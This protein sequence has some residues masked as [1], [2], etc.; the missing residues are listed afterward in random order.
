M[1]ARDYKSASDLVTV[2]DTTQ[3]TSPANGCNPAPGAPSHPLSAQAHPP[4]AVIALAGNTIGRAE[5]NGGNGTGFCETG[6][7]Y[8]LTKTDVHGVAVAYP[9][10]TQNC[11]PGHNS[12]GLGFGQEGDPSFT[13]T[14]GHSHAV[15]YRTNAA[16][17][18]M[19][20]VDV[21]ATLNT[22]TDPTGQFL[23]QPVAFAQNTRDEV[24]EMDVV[25]V[26]AAQPGMKQT[27]YVRQSMQVRRLTPRECERLQG[28]PVDFTLIPGDTPISKIRR[29][30]LDMD[31]V[32][33]LHR[34]GRLTFEQCMNAAADG[35]RYKALGNS[36]A[37]PCMAFIGRRIERALAEPWPELIP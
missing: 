20:Q 10:D 13:I 31:Y 12:G 11:S 29:E 7:C 6:E 17:Q 33:Y 23:L 37:T 24:R 18:V 36:M 27:S 35:P 21:C 26:L 5:H 2:F 19:P 32:K 22:Q 3:I 4:L 34:G 16:G 14:K 15:A 9:L 8:T 1:S 28:F 25:G 30:K